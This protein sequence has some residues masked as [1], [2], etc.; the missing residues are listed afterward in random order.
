MIWPGFGLR[1]VRSL[2]WQ[3]D[4]VAIKLIIINFVYEVNDDNVE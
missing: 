3:L 4:Y 2:I 1:L